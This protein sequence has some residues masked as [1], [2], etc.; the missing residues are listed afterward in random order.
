M[1]FDP[2]TGEASDP[3]APKITASSMLKLQ[4]H[5]EASR[6]FLKYYES[7]DQYCWTFRNSSCETGRDSRT[8]RGPFSPHIE[9]QDMPEQP[10]RPRHNGWL[11]D[12]ELQH[13]RP[14]NL[15]QP[16]EARQLNADSDKENSS[17]A[18]SWAKRVRKVAQLSSLAGEN[19]EGTSEAPPGDILRETLSEGL[20]KR[21]S[22]E[23]PRSPVP[24]KL[25]R[26]DEKVL[27][28]PAPNP[29]VDEATQTEA[30]QSSASKVTL[31]SRKRIVSKLGVDKNQ[32][33]GQLGEKSRV[34]IKE[35]AAQ[36]GK[37]S[38]GP[39]EDLR[40]P[41]R[42]NMKESTAD[43]KDKDGAGEVKK[44]PEQAEKPWRTNMKAGGKIEATAEV[45]VTKKAGETGAE[46]KPWRINMKKL[47]DKPP[48]VVVMT[49]K[50]HYGDRD[51]VRKYKLEKQKREKALREEKER[52][53]GNL[54]LH[55]P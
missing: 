32:D 21:K 35:Q 36:K 38:E 12:T 10:S 54:N 47:E 18:P 29:A 13:R 33:K 26:R 16:E 22:P 49:K 3:F 44:R 6:N 52:E 45:V 19:M 53:G 24:M 31:M 9:G 55:I 48:E 34:E 15:S 2:F 42:I 14:E 46:D 7:K 27:R 41:W 5:Q 23:E 39:G 28:E 20:L 37:P 17:V 50:R 4:E 40:R 8:Q 51:D 43:N 25:T 1:N 30:G 11:K